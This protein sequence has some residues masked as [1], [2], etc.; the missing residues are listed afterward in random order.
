MKKIIALLLMAVMMLALAGCACSSSKETIVNNKAIPNRRNILS[1][2]VKANFILLAPL[3]AY[4]S[5]LTE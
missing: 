2:F 4:D 1:E 3:V 5:S